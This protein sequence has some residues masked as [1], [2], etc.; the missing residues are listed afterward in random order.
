MNF[1]TQN[2]GE[3]KVTMRNRTSAGRDNSLAAETS[4]SLHQ[5]VLAEN[6]F[7]RVRDLAYRLAGISLG[8]HKRDMVYSRLVRRLRALNLNSFR[9]Y[10]D[11]VEK[12]GTE[13]QSFLNALTTNLT[14]FFREEH[15]FPI[16]VRHAQAKA[17]HGGVVRLWSA[18]SSTGEEPYSMAI[19]LAEGFNTITPPIRLFA[20]DI[21]TDVLQRAQAGIYPLDA[22]NRLPSTSLR[23]FFLRGVGPQEGSARV[24]PELQNLVTFRQL[25]LLA[26]TWEIETPMDAIFCRNVMIYF[27]KP[28]QREVVE[29]F[30]QVL[31]PDGLLFMGHAESLQHV[32][33]LVKPIGQTVYSLT[34]QAIATKTR[35]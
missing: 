2:S 14:Y 24:R 35:R 31:A 18:A 34:P 8:P 21:D 25:N 7:N 30:V 17:A 10:L 9:V 23:R 28:T 1:L 19:A 22:V 5:F 33:D 15:H 6:D 32:A 27:D 4:D 3:W 11:Q 29:G 26:E 13:V 16:L 20:T 12:G